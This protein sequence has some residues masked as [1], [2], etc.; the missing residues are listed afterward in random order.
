MNDL[1]GL[2][3]TWIHHQRLQGLSRCPLYRVPILGSSEVSSSQGAQFV[4]LL[5]H[6]ISSV[7]S[8]VSVVLM[9][10]IA[11]RINMAMFNAAPVGSAVRLAGRCELQQQ[12]ILQTVDGGSLPIQTTTALEIPANQMVEIMGTKGLQGQLCATSV[13]K[14]PGEIDGDLWNQAIQL[15]HHSKLRHLFQPAPSG[16]SGPS[17]PSA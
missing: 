7:V 4:L 12:W 8:V 6:P 13:S 5:F 11:E 17:G 15:A 1:N 3:F 16:P 2:G 14:L 10:A 9:A